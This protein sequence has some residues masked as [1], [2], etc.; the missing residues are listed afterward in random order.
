MHANFVSHLTAKSGRR[1]IHAPALR[2][3]SS[4]FVPP[5]IAASSDRKTGKMSKSSHALDTGWWRDLIMARV[6]SLE[7][8]QA[9]PKGEKSVCSISADRPAIFQPCL[10]T[11]QK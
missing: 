3:L 11:W 4:T 1:A 10:P 9:Q 5:R 6:A 7:R 2:C 8:F